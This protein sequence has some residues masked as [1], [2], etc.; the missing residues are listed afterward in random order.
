VSFPTAELA[1]S[2]SRGYGTSF[3]APSPGRATLVL[4]ASGSN[5]R[6]L[7]TVIARTVKVASG[8]KRVTKAGKV[9]VTA[10][11]TRKARSKLRRKKKVKV[12]AVLTFKDA[13]GRIGTKTKKLTLKR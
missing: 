2:L 5:A 11:F 12:T 6:G 10:K 9:K 1:P 13:S 8:S 7:R 3:T 4:T